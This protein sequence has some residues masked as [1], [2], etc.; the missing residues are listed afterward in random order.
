MK[1][2]LA[3][4]VTTILVA[5]AAAQTVPAQPR[6]M[7]AE[8]KSD[9]CTLFPDGNYR[10]C[11]VEHDKDYFFGGSLGDRRASDKRLYRCVKAKQGWENKLAAPLMFIGVRVGGV[12]FLPTPFK[13]GFGKKKMKGATLRAPLGSPD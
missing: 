3:I 1:H 6:L 10:I 9:G 4:L 11:C 7:P 5:A 8:F 13:W 12:S 2:A